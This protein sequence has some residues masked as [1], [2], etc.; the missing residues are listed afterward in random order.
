MYCSTFLPSTAPWTSA[1]RKWMP[2]HT[3]ASMT[4]LSASEK[5]S[6]VLPGHGAGRHLLL[7]AVKETLLVPKNS[8]SV[9]T[10]ALLMQAFLAE[11]ADPAR[12]AR[13]LTVHYLAPAIEGPAELTVRTER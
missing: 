13:S 7:I 2:L 3:R 1:V 4:S 5:R 9:F 6:K 8:F 11:V 10:T 12:H